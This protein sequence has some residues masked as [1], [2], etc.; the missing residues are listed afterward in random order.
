M[1]N[2]R[3]VALCSNSVQQTADNKKARALMLAISPNKKSRAGVGNFRSVSGV[4]HIQDAQDWRDFE[5]GGSDETMDKAW[6]NY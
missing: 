5:S 4:V 3:Q 2:I 1:Q 6:K